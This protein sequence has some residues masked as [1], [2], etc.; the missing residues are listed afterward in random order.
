MLDVSTHQPRHSAGWVLAFA[1]FLLAPLRGC[2]YLAPSQRAPS[3]FAQGHGPPPHA[4]AHGHRHRRHQ[5]ELEL[6]FDAG[7]GVYSVVGR[8]D[9]YWHRDRYLHWT[10]GSW[11]VSRRFDGRWAGIS[12]DAVPAGLVS[13]HSKHHRKKKHRKKH[14]WPAKHRH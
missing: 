1:V 3:I 9:Y 6:V 11:R 2:V 4:P 10:S 12:I 5:D 7:L 14:R 8:P 13:K